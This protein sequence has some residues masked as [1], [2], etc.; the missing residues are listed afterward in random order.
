EA[1]PHIAP[2]ARFERGEVLLRQFRIERLEARAIVPQYAVVLRQL[3]EVVLGV[4]KLLLVRPVEADDDLAQEAHLRELFYD[5][6][7]RRALELG[8][9]RGQDER[10]GAG[11]GEGEK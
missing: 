8:N 3:G 1:I 10:Y 2:L 11:E 7:Q 6:G 5:V 9:E 4:A